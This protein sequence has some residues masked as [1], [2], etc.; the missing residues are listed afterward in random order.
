MNT[1]TVL[2]IEGESFL[3]NGQPTYAGK[4]F[5]GHSIEGL[6]FNSR[7]IQ[8]IFDDENP[9]TAQHWA[10]PDTGVWDAARNTSEFCA[11]LP[12]YKQ[13]GLLGVT[14]GLQGGG[15]NYAPDIYHHYH[16]SAFAPDGSLKQ[17][18]LDRL[19]QVLKA[20]DDCGMVVIV[21][22]T[23][24]MHRNVFANQQAVDRGI[25]NATEW[26]LQSGYRN[27]I[28][29]IMNEARDDLTPYFSTNQIPRYLDM[30][31]QTTLDGRRLLVGN[32]AFP[33]HVIPS[34]EWLAA[35][36]I[37][38][39]HGNN[40]TPDELRQKLREWRSLAPIKQRPRPIL[41]NED[42]TLIE[43]MDVAIEEGVSWGFYHQGYGS[44]YQHDR[45]IN[46]HHHPRETDYAKLSGF[47]TLPIN[48]SINDPWKRAFFE[49]LKA[50]TGGFPLQL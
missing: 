11:M 18:Y 6:L 14:V 21:S 5:R 29:E 24:A 33:D 35:E 10:S 17:P 48:W 16:T 23:Y 3:I 4:S 1:G 38:M 41:I 36:D 39:P 32:S 44:M 26:L 2:S 46:W 37:T 42:S 27:I 43:N 15:S 34:D 13:H 31:R 8:A 25:R 9:E 45:F 20:T 12:I 50:V 7:M 47:Q 19:A 40:H 30:V 28:V 49:H 22:Y